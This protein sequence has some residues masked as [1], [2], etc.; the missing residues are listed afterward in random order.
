[1]SAEA[2]PAAWRARGRGGGARAAGRQRTKA[3]TCEHSAGREAKH[4]AERLCVKGCLCRVC[5]L[6]VGDGDIHT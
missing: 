2:A 1:M 5:R 6:L 4:R 3:V